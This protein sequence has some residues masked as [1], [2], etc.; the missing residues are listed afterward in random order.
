MVKVRR[1]TFS[2]PPIANLPIGWLFAA[3]LL[4]TSMFSMAQ[5]P[6]PD[7]ADCNGNQ[8]P[9][10]L[11]QAELR[12][13]SGVDFG[14][15]D[16]NAGPG[17]TSSVR[18]INLGEAPFPLDGAGIEI[19]GAHASDFQIIS[20][21]H[22]VPD[23]FREPQFTPGVTTDIV[24]RTAD[25]GLPPSDHEL[26]LDLYE[27]TGGVMPGA[28]PFVVY[29]HGGAFLSGSKSDADATDFGF[30]MAE[31]GYVVASIEY[32]L[33]GDFPPDDLPDYYDDSG[34][35]QGICGL[36]GLC[37]AP[38]EI[39]GAFK[40]G[41]AAAI[42]D[43]RGA[44]SW[45]RSNKEALN[46]RTDLVGLAGFSAGAMTA[47]SAG[48]DRDFGI[49]WGVGAIIDRSGGMNGNED[50]VEAGEAAVFVHH[51]NTDFVVNVSQARSLR[52]RVN[53]VGLPIE[54]RE[55]GGG[56]TALAMSAPIG[57]ST[58]Q[59]RYAKFL[60]DHLGLAEVAQAPAAPADAVPAGMRKR[61]WIAFDPSAPGPRSAQLAALRGCAGP[62]LVLPLTGM[63]IG[64][65]PTA[66][67]T[68]EPTPTVTST[69]T[70]PAPSPTPLCCGGDADL[71]GG[72][73]DALDFIAVQS[74]FGA[75]GPA[76]RA[77]D[78]DCSGGLID[79]ADFIA[80]QTNFGRDCG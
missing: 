64:S 73:V 79:A 44:V 27:P 72:F 80:V 4:L 51:G 66:T 59:G 74:S 68:P 61:V 46:L 18:L 2:N 15:R 77:G 47:L 60:Y 43:A 10:V 39:L 37:P 65:V 8:I 11:E 42:R 71:S 3:A 35:A 20:A 22:I 14:S 38:P 17:P 24:Y 25:A 52:D 13:P 56:H 62:D 70:H 69:A 54:Y 5:T 36:L 76:G 50:F 63:G 31:C 75:E 29:L 67:A 33:I 48:Y 32:R 34:F 26:H 23:L 7:P 40:S 55:F 28:R 1:K 45:A 78:A 53:A 12:P 41:V 16:V 19:R 21:E 9:D 30:G 57:G 58:V 6:T 49:S